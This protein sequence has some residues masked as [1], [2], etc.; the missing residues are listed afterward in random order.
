MTNVVLNGNAYSD[1]G[2][3]AR[4]MQ[5][6][7]H[8]QWLL[9]MLGDA[10]ISVDSATAAAAAASG[11]ATA[12]GLSANASAQSAQ[13]ALDAFNAA[14]ALGSG[15]TAVTSTVADGV[16]VVLRVTDWTGGKGPKPATGYV[17]S[18]GLVATAALAANIR[19]AVAYA[20]LTGKPTLGT[21]APMNV[22]ATA[23]T[24]ATS[25]QVVRGDDPRLAVSAT[26]GTQ[27]Y[28]TS[29]SIAKSAFGTATMVLVELW[30]GGGSGAALCVSGTSLSGAG[31]GEGGE[32]A[33]VL[34]QIASLSADTTLTI[35]AGGTS[36]V[37][38]NVGIADGN[39]GGNTTFGSFLTA[40]GGI[41]GPST[42]NGAAEKGALA[43][44]NGGAGGGGSGTVPVSDKLRKSSGV[45]G[46]SVYGGGGGGCG[47]TSG[48]VPSTAGGVSQFA[49]NGGDGASNTTADVSASAGVAP[50]GAGGGAI[51]GSSKKATSGAGARGQARLT[52]W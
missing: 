25:A 19:G 35:G 46:S 50:S 40:F 42:A 27:L 18:S 38:S 3:A 2:S 15:W 44:K 23:G 21:A 20:D 51:A 39:A 52:W 14:N 5:G 9:P 28:T 48:N 16:R 26:R 10:M 29:Q 11:S 34:L 7:G 41:G 6:G 17:G 4:D 30:A 31:G 33:Q 43:G 45:G 12:A 37:A 36:A 24:A 32:Y 22:P 49:G 8:R 13:D 1:D 47:A